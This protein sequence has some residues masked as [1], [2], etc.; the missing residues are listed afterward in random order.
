MLGRGGVREEVVDIIGILGAVLGV[1]VWLGRVVL[2][3]WEVGV[4]FDCIWSGCVHASEFGEGV[5]ID[6]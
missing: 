4:R 3:E 6:E 5:V 2:G 1:G